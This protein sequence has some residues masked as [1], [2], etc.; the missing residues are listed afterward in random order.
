[1]IKGILDLHPATISYVSCDPATLARDLP[2]LLSAGYRLESLTLA[3]LVPQTF[4]L[5]TIAVL[6]REPTS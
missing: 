3:D 2:G 6:S 5:E 4:H 1:V